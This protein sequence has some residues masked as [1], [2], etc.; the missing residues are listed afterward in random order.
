MRKH[1]NFAFL[2]RIIYFLNLY[3]CCLSFP[4]Y[5]LGIVPWLIIQENRASLFTTPHPPK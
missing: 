1:V 2:R 3:E 4:P 5:T